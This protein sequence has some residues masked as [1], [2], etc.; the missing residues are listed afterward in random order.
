MSHFA[1]MSDTFKESPRQ[2][3]D[4]YV[5]YSGRENFVTA[6]VNRDGATLNWHRNAEIQQWNCRPRMFQPVMLLF[7]RKWGNLCPVSRDS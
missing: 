7:A 5:V 4:K 6:P 1:T 2:S 3:G